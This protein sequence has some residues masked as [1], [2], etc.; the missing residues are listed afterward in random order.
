MIW[1]SKLK[2]SVRLIGFVATATG[3]SVYSF[4]SGTQIRGGRAGASSL[5]RS[6]ERTRLID[7]GSRGGSVS[8]SQTDFDS[9]SVNNPTVSSPAVPVDDGPLSF[10]N[11]RTNPDPQGGVVGMSANDD[12]FDAEGSRRVG[13]RGERLISLA[14]ERKTQ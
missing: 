3:Q 7:G 12:V 2:S 13:S 14:D 11:H 1:W 6:D 8:S 4:H 9:L 5:Y 10:P